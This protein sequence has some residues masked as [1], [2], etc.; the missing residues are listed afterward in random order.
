MMPPAVPSAFTMESRAPQPVVSQSVDANAIQVPS[1]DQAG[2]APFG[3]EVSRDAPD[4][5]AF[6]M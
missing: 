5:S 2:A 3:P 4:P 1:G 6:M